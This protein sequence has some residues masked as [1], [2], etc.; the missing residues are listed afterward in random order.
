MFQ[1]LAAAV[2][3]ALMLFSF[4]GFVTEDSTFDLLILCMVT[5][6][7]WLLCGL[8]RFY[9]L[10]EFRRRRKLIVTV[11]LPICLCTSV[12]YAATGDVKWVA[13]ETNGWVAQICFEGYNANGQWKMSTVTNFTAVTNAPS[14]TLTTQ[15]Y[16]T[17]AVLTNYSIS[18]TGTKELRFPYGEGGQTTV[19]FIPYAITNGSDL[20]GRFALS[21]YIYAGDS[22]V[23]CV[24]PSG[25]YSN[26]AARSAFS[27]TN[28]STNLY[29]KPVGNW[30]RPPF[31]KFSDG[32][33]ELGFWAVGPGAHFMNN[34][35]P[36]ACV[37]FWATDES[38]TSTATNRV[39]FPTVRSDAFAQQDAVPVWEYM[40][41]LD[42]TPLAKTNLCKIQARIYPWWGTNVLDTSATG[43]T[44]EANTMELTY[45]YFF[46]DE[47]NDFG[48]SVAVVDPVNGNDTT[49]KATNR[50]SFNVSL[51][52]PAFSNISAAY[53]AIA[54]T[55]QIL[56][57]HSM[58]GGSVIYAQP[59][60][61]YLW[62]GGTA[63]TTNRQSKT[64]LL[65]T[66]FPGVDRSQVV[67]SNGAGG[68]TLRDLTCVSNVTLSSQGT[69]TFLNAG[70]A[71]FARCMVTNNLAPRL[72]DNCTNTFFTH[73]TVYEM[74]QGLGSGAGGTAFNNWKLTRGNTI[75]NNVIMT[76]VPG[77]FIGN[78]RDG[79]AT[80]FY[81][82]T[83]GNFTTRRPPSYPI[84]AHNIWRNTYAS[85]DVIG[86]Y[87]AADDVKNTNGFA[88][89]QNLIENVNTN[90][91]SARCMAICSSAQSTPDTNDVSNGFILHN[92]MVGQRFNC[93]ENAGGNATNSVSANRN[94]WEVRNNYFDTFNTKDDIHYTPAGVRQGSWPISWGVGFSGNVDLNPDQMDSG[95]W[96][97]DFIG[98]YSYVVVPTTT[99]SF[100]RY[101]PRFY[102]NRS[103]QVGD[104]LTA[105]NGDYRMRAST[106]IRYM[107]PHWILP[108]DIAGQPLTANRNQVGAYAGE[109]TSYLINSGNKTFLR[110]SNKTTLQP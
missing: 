88:V 60:S 51:P 98:R 16:T 49:G 76:Y 58:V 80:N 103:A 21:D 75:S 55:N 93:G 73:N 6:G 108:Y 32:T 54:R 99:I 2:S 82:V 47:N 57:G 67:I 61:N 94:N 84:I 87:Y 105:G 102:S 4:W 72:I 41:S 89:A 14:F 33:V 95:S 68:F 42:V 25:C 13:I 31:Q 9:S 10:L 74:P 20:I 56:H 38:G 101:F 69:A 26:N 110:G 65:F 24:V 37:D 52:P 86:L 39:V 11:L 85:S 18:I 5:P 3:F 29:A 91:G 15:G 50:A 63:T 71:W 81:T 46:N 90:F 83:M 96:Y 17:N 106:P 1:L 19:N 100:A 53:T 40:S 30:T 70:N 28:H 104:P 59:Y 92:T 8:A 78:Y 45:S 66:P 48:G 107:T 35:L 62:V 109:F 7:F 44:Y 79:G 23:V 36:V 43:F 64:W 27:I 77:M 12:M 34:G 22:N 97:F